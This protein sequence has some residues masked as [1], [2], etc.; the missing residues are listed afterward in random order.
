MALVI[1]KAT[2]VDFLFS[3][4]YL[5]IV[6]FVMIFYFLQKVPLNFNFPY[7]G[8]LLSSVWITTGGT[9]CMTS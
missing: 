2:Q 3:F 8:H 6:Y 9:V 7:Y 1:F 5:F 4:V